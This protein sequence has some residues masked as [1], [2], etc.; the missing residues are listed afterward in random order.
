MF[1][2]FLCYISDT[3]FSPF[4]LSLHFILL[5]VSKWPPFLTCPFQ[6]WFIVNPTTTKS[7]E[8][9]MKIKQ[10]QQ[11]EEKQRQQPGSLQSLRRQQQPRTE[12]EESQPEP[13][14]GKGQDGNEELV[15]STL[16]KGTEQEPVPAQTQKA[17]PAKITHKR[18]RK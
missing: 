11:E 4:F 2:L 15:V 12:P 13:R 1:P 16:C 8:K 14:A 3:I 6:D 7:F 17:E 18:G 5:G 9:L 10:R